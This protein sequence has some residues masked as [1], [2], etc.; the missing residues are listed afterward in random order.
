MK[1]PGVR[2]ALAKAPPSDA[3]ATPHP[4]RL[5]FPFDFS[6]SPD[7]LDTEYP[8][9]FADTLGSTDRLLGGRT[10]H[11]VDCGVMVCFHYSPRHVRPTGSYLLSENNF[12]FYGPH[13]YFFVAC[14]NRQG[15]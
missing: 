2:L 3:D 14:V 15:G 7:T 1:L 8:E 4:W 10:F 5:R 9:P 12:S 6:V 11:P 13:V